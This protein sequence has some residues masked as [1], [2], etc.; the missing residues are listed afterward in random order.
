MQYTHLGRTGLRVSP[1]CLGTMNFGWKT[2]ETDSF[3]I[4]DR[5]LALGINFFD[6]A[7]MYGWEG[8]RGDTERILGR[9]WKGDAA[10]RD[11]VVLA[12]K[13]YH[14]MPEDHPEPNRGTVGLSARK[15]IR[16]C[17]DSLT[18]LQTDWIDLYQ[19]HHVDRSC[20]WD[21]IWEA[22]ETLIRQGK[23]VYVGSSNHAAWDI[24]TANQVASRHHL[25]GLVSEQSLYNLNAR[26][27]ELEVIPC[28]RHYGVGVIPWSP[29]GGGLLGG[30]L[31]K[32]DGARRVSEKMRER[33]EQM[34]PQLEAW[35]GLCAELGEHPA[36]VA[37]AWLMHNEVVTAPI[38]GPRT[39][40][41]LD[42]AVR[43]AEIELS[44]E[45][46]ATLDEIWPGPG[47]E[48]PVAY[49]W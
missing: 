46:L 2:E 23:I 16:H 32:I 22:M 5:A 12:T 1:I 48:A 3:A 49:A 33:V 38:I 18:R 19:M 17:E 27:I 34:R 36:D 14:A 41:Q 4:M 8:E 37:L 39:M 47:G 9:W 11:R 6:T 21:E 7:D 24:A 29:L 20:P 43:A 31:G 25:V 26:M 13:V 10:K 30:V 15:I 28:C 45:T 35:E 44:E 40:E 42:G